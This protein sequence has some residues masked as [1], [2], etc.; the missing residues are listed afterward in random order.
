[1]DEFGVGKCDK[2]AEEEA[3]CVLIVCFTEKAEWR[4]ILSGV[5]FVW[6]EMSS[7]GV[8]YYLLPISMLCLRQ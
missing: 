5:D 3:G 2:F 1:L 6:V 7:V 4:G 8:N